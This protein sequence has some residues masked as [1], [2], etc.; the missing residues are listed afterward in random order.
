[1]GCLHAAAKGLAERGARGALK[2]NGCKL[3]EGKFGLDVRK[4][5]VTLRVVRLR[6]RAV[7]APSLELLKAWLDGA[8]SATNGRYLCPWGGSSSHTFL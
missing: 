3:E 5:F 7:L 6:H 1:L 4:D 2:G 8:L